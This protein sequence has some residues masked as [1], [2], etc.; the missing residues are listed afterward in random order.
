MDARNSTVWDW[1]SRFQE[2][3]LDPRLW[4]IVLQEL[5]DATGSERAQLVGLG[6]DLVSRFY[7]PTTVESGQLDDF[8]RI[9]GYSPEI[10][11]RLAADAGTDELA[12]VHEAHYDQARL[13]LRREDYVD[14]CEQYRI[15]WGCQAALIRDADTLVGLTVLR[16]RDDGRTDESQRAIFAAAARAAR[17]AVRMQRAIER[18]GLDLLSGTLEATALPCLLLDEQGRIGAMTAAAERLFVQKPTLRAVDDRLC[19]RTTEDSRRID[20]AI[21]SVLEPGGTSHVRVPVY[22]TPPMPDLVL[23][24]FALPPR[25]WALAF[26]PRVLVSIRDPRTN[27]RSGA[28]V[29]ADAFGLTPAEAQ[30]TIHLC[31]GHPRERIAQARGVSQETLKVQLKRIYQKTG[32]A[33]EAELVVLIN[34][35]LG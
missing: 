2:A 7:W 34:N 33:R 29:L 24:L 13:G 18:R 1:E 11:Y 26:V 32:C 23:D 28:T 3:A 19:S 9:E 22:R 5:A 20:L 35:L 10:N 21:R 12:I 16:S 14:H 8:I 17:N 30:V 6:S 27:T 15:P 25:E 31:E 4:I